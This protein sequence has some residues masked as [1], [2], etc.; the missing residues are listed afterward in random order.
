MENDVRVKKNMVRTTQSRVE[1]M[2]KIAWT[3]RDTSADDKHVESGVRAVGG[4]GPGAVSSSA[5]LSRV[6]NGEFG[7]KKKKK[8]T[9]PIKIS[10]VSGRQSPVSSVRVIY[11]NVFFFSTRFRFS[12]GSCVSCFG[13]LQY[14]DDFSGVSL[15][16]RVCVWIVF[17]KG[18]VARMTEGAGVKVM[19]VREIARGDSEDTTNAHEV[20][21]RTGLEVITYVHVRRI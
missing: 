15:V 21:C 11:L 10:K 12:L 2:A 1:M 9:S 13:R 6:E 16:A 4:E 8:K 20:R 5:G 19:K 3:R 14:F 17:G 7:K 18:H